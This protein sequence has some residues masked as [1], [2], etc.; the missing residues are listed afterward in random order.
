MSHTHHHIRG[1][2]VVVKIITPPWT[3]PPNH[4][5]HRKED[6]QDAPMHDHRVVDAISRNVN[7][8]NWINRGG[9]TLLLAEGRG[10]SGIKIKQM[11]LL[12]DILPLIFAR[13]GDEDGGG[14]NYSVNSG[15]G[16]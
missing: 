6:T 16:N 15:V 3:R 13:L 12:C 5:H 1:L 10:N 4:R 8:K 2:A 11:T 9:G 7:A 14:G